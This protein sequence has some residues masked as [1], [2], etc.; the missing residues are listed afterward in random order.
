MPIIT[1]PVGQSAQLFTE[2]SSVLREFS[3]EGPPNLHCD[4]TY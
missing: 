2:I 3:Q 1:G 4:F